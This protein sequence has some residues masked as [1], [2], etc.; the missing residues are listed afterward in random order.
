VKLG[1]LKD[2]GN[3][4]YTAQRYREAIEKFSEGIS[5]YLQGDQNAFRADK[6]VKLK[7]THLYTNRSLS[8]HQLGDQ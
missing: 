4:H 1:K 7:V 8:H 6:D 3:A 5:I 2:Q